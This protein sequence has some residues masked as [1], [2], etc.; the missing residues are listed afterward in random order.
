MYKVNVEDKIGIF[1][2]NVKFQSL[3]NSMVIYYIPF[4]IISFLLSWHS[5]TFYIKVYF[6]SSSAWP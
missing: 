4:H 2:I 5:F 3:S 6:F 1:I